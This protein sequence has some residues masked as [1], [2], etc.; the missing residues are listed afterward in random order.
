MAPIP[1]GFPDSP[2][3]ERSIHTEEFAM[4]IVRLAAVVLFVHGLIGQTFRGSIAGV[5]TDASGAAIAGAG[6]KLDSPSTGLSHA[7]ATNT[8][9]QY[10][11]PDLPVGEYIV[12]VSHTGFEAKRVDR[13]EV[14]VSRITNLDV[15]LGIA[16]QQQVIEVSAA[17]ATL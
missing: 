14:A 3:S 15:R 7:V 10:S 1:S 11:F 12:T 2:R 16:Q 8:Q 17:A 9:G 4:R 13:V 6:V 5:V